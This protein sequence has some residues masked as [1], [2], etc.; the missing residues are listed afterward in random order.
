MKN[1]YP[2]NLIEDT[3]GYVVTFVDIP[4][5]LT[6]GDTLEEALEMAAD[7]LATAME[8]YFEDKRAVP[9]ASKPAKGQPTVSLPASIWAKVL[10]LNEVVGQNLRPI[11]VAKKMGTRPQQVNRILDLKHPTK[12]DTLAAAFKAVGKEL[13]LSIV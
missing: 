6:Q 4:E 10:L 8:F 11:D 3:G 5:A 1:A 2:I 7:A 13:T 9:A 12:I